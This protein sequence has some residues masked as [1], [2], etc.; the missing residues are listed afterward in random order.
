MN[1]GD[2]I[3]KILRRYAAFYDERPCPTEH[4]SVAIQFNWKWDTLF[5]NKPLFTADSILYDYSALLDMEVN[6]ENYEKF[7]RDPCMGVKAFEISKVSYS[8]AEEIMLRN[9][10]AHERFEKLLAKAEKIKSIMEE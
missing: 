4:R 2:F 3:S 9:L 8:K 1:R 5:A 10:Q 6:R 7:L